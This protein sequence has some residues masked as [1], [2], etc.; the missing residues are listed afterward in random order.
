MEYIFLITWAI[1]I[2]LASY[3]FQQRGH[4]LISGLLLG[5]FF[6]PIGVIITL[7]IP[8]SDEVKEKKEK[9]SKMEKIEAGEMKKCP[10]CAEIINY[11][12]II[13]R[14]CGKEQP[15]IPEKDEAQF[16]PK[17]HCRRLPTSSENYIK[18]SNCNFEQW[19]GLKMCQKC[20]LEFYE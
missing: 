14:Y 5:L 8:E 11:E 3:S 17:I 9:Y 20:G 10:F 7:I 18:C 1:F 16:N 4:S 19:A 12:A 6:G 15:P 13:C 2:I